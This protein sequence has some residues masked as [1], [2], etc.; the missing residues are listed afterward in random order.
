[1][2][3]TKVE[4]WKDVPNYKGI[5]KVSSLGR[6][7]SLSR[8]VATYQGERTVKERYMAENDNGNGYKYVNLSDEGIVTRNYIH[9]LVAQVFI[10]NPEGKE[11][12]NHINGDKADNQSSNL[13]WSTRRDN[14]Q[15]A[16]DIGLKNGSISEIDVIQLEMIKDLLKT[17]KYS[18]PEL[19]E[20]FKV[21]DTMMLK[22]RKGTVESKLTFENVKRNKISNGY[23][24]IVYDKEKKEE[25]KFMSAQ[26]ASE[27]YGHWSGYFSELN[28]KQGGENKRFKVKFV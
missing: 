13:E 18:L 3:T 8:K 10:P 15:H 26:Q 11:E 2:E 21:S 1:M 27:H 7:K 25:K 5:Y 12:V 16:Y 19:R 14:E 28:R 9:R 20:V 22:I 6:V 4:V 24:T 23:Q 17:K